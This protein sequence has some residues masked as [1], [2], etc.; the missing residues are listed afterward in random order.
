MT[1]VKVLKSLAV[2]ESSGLRVLKYHEVTLSLGPR[3][4]TNVECVGCVE[5]RDMTRIYI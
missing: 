5:E 4:A 1:D 2:A 3:Y